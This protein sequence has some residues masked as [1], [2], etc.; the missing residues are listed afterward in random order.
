[1][2]DRKKK[3]VLSSHRAGGRGQP[4]PTVPT[5]PP[6]P[7]GPPVTPVP[8]LPPLP[9]N[10]HIPPVP[11]T[12]P[13]PLPT[14]T[15]VKTK[16]EKKKDARSISPK[17]KKDKKPSDGKKVPNELL[18]GVIT[19]IRNPLTKLLG[20]AYSEFPGRGKVSSTGFV[21]E[22]YLK[23]GT[24]E[25]NAFYDH[26]KS[27]VCLGELMCVTEI[28]QLEK[29][30]GNY[31]KFMTKFYDIWTKRILSAND[32]VDFNGQL[33]AVEED[34]P[35]NLSG[36]DASAIQHLIDKYWDVTKD[37]PKSLSDVV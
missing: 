15:A 11:T 4:V 35:V 18:D 30:H 12:P 24:D 6:V 21:P 25:Y 19:H 9:T 32:E 23:K 1:M 37:K 13:P 31:E 8:T 5:V 27:Q 3:T 26:C 33:K 34:T 16:K 2:D 22:K 36:T 29:H 10:P 14:Q 20:G 28:D 17:P 7:T